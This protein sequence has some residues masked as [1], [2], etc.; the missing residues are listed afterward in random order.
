M[1]ERERNSETEIYKREGGQGGGGELGM[2]GGGGR[3]A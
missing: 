1:G 3:E 2:G